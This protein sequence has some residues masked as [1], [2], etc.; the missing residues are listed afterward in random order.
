MLSSFF[1]FLKS[2]KKFKKN[3]KFIFFKN[4]FKKFFKDEK[5]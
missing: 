1:N 3:D 4:V 5:L 2:D